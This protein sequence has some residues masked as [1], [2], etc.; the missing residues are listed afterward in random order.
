MERT[1][2][3]QQAD[4]A[5]AVDVNAARK[6]FDLSLKDFGPYRCD[7]TRSSAAS[8]SVAMTAGG[9]FRRGRAIGHDRGITSRDTVRAVKFLHSGQFFAAAQKVLK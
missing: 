1:W 7:F 9:V 4:I 2:R 6:A 5:A 3:F 8:S